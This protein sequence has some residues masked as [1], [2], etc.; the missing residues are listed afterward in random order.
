[1][2]TRDWIEL[3]GWIA[4]T[5]FSAGVTWATVRFQGRETRL[6]VDA[7]KTRVKELEFC[8]GVDTLVSYGASKK[9]HEVLEQIA[10][11]VESVLKRKKRG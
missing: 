6:E 8:M 7:L 3:F 5:A 1:M 4:G 9:Q 11:M 10:R 2:D